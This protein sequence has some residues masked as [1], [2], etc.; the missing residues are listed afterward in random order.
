MRLFSIMLVLLSVA[1]APVPKPP[2]DKPA[3]APKIMEL[4]G[5]R[6][7]ET[8]LNGDYLLLTD[9]LIPAGSRLV[10]KPGTTIKIRQAEATKIDPE[11]LSSMTEIL[12]RGTL[13]VEGTTAAPVV[14]EP[15]ISRQSGDPLWAGVIL[16]HARSSS[17]RSVR[18]SGAETG[19]FLVDAQ[20]ELSESRIEQ[21]RYG[22]IIQG[23][24]PVLKDN[25]IGRGESGLYIWDAATPAFSGNLIHNNDEEGIYIDR[26][27]RPVFS[28]D[29]ARQNAIGLV[30]SERPDSRLLSLTENAEV[31]RRLSPRRETE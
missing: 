22:V 7:G 3:A 2:A 10:V 27:S 12:I 31:W 14:I 26:T 4:G 11:Y 23:G 18:I 28:A 6:V 8:V 25:R 16:D 30:A 5:V 13:I 24:A 9:L 21:N 17:V 20:V 1:C 15:E 29:H 19:L